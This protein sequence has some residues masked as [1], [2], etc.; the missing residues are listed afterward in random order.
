MARTTAPSPRPAPPTQ[1]TQSTQS[2][3][4][5][6]L[7]HVPLV[8]APLEHAP[9]E[10]ASHGSP[11]H[12]APDRWLATGAA[13]LE[14]AIRERAYE[15]YRARGRGPGSAEDDWRQAELDLRGPGGPGGPGR[16]AGDR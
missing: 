8:H 3:Q 7:E 4:H 5:A 16:P 2:T 6:P 9:H 10:N 11:Q 15:L 13:L 12:P 14:Q 1:P